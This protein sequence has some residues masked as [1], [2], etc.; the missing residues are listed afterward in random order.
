M[1][2]KYET[3]L[4][5]DDRNSSHTLIAELVG[6]DKRVLDVGCAT[7]Y[8]AEV[9]VER[10][11]RVT[12]IEADPEAAR[13]A[14]KYCERVIVGDVEDPS[15]DKQLDEGSFDV[16]VFGDVLEHLKDPLRTLKRLK[17]FLRPEGYVVA[18]IPNVAHGSVRLAL[19][20]GKFQYRPLGL[21]D[22][23]HLRFFTR[24]SVEQLFDDAGFLMGEL[25]RTRRGIFDTEVEI[26]RELVTS[27]ILKVVRSD[28]EALT[29]QFVLTA[30]LPLGEAATVTKL[31]DRIRLLSEQLTQRGATIQELDE[32]A[33]EL[34]RQLDA[35][36]EQLAERDRTIYKLNRKLRNFE[37]LQRQLDSRTEQLAEREREVARLAQEVA[38]R[39]DRMARLVQFGK[40]DA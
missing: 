22:D 12:G 7:G 9:L 1:A 40:E 32:K 5:L 37:E 18:S 4:D 6:P 38:D 19:I 24:E 25:R 28:S 35:S 33:R 23:T 16:I 10:G 21:L 14:E 11:C 3:D 31:A 20:Q 29:Y 13:Q 39:N 15:L 34:A 27:E 26:D 8:L 30:Y 36:H 17:L 2:S